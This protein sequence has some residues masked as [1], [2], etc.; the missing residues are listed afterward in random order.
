MA[1]ARRARG[2]DPIAGVRRSMWQRTRRPPGAPVRAVRAAAPLPPGGRAARRRSA[3]G[4]RQSSEAS[5]TAGRSC[6]SDD[7]VLCG[8]ES[9]DAERSE[10]VGQHVHVGQ[11]GGEEHCSPGSCRCGDDRIEGARARR[12]ARDACGSC[13]CL[14]HRGYLAAPERGREPCLPTAPPRLC[15]R[16][17]AH[18]RWDVS[19]DGATHPRPSARLSSLQGDEDAGV[20]AYAGHARSTASRSPSGIDPCSTS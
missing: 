5:M 16:S 4:A 13:E 15:Q 8:S 20:E 11:I 17:R 6:R 2:D 12:P 10:V 14:G 3:R 18:K 7:R 19:L 9:D 1:S